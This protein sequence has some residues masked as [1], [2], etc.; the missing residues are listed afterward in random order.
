MTIATNREVLLV[1]DTISDV[2]VL[3]D[4]IKDLPFKITLHVVH[5]GE[6]ALNFLNK[7]GKY[8]K[9]PRPDLVLLD[10]NLPKING[11]EVL[12]EVKNDK[13]LM[14]IPVVIITTSNAQEDINRAYKLHANS[15]IKKSFNLEESSS[16]ILRLFDFWFNTALLPSSSGQH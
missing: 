16:T 6:E 15:Y 11:W 1:E 13:D 10:L 7:K 4:S 8:K 12:L 14:M 3:T 2:L 5:D 9:A